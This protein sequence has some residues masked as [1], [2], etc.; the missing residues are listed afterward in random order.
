[1]S[2]RD[3]ARTIW[4]AALSGLS[5]MAP[6]VPL[7]LMAASIQHIVSSGGILDTI[8]YSAARAFENASPF[9]GALLVFFSALGIEFFI[10]SGSAKAFLVMPI[11]LP[12]GDLVGITRQM[13]VTAYC[14]GDGFTNLAYPTSA[15]L[16][17]CLG[18]GSV[19]YGRWLRW[20]LPLW[21][22]LLLI[23]LI[24]LALGT[25]IGLGP[26]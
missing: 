25:A 19:S 26:I 9:G 6:A 22:G 20:T 16:L 14:F 13:V 4:Q 11:L 12:L 15:V 7:I 8:L 3:D 10:S 1:M 24:F 23:T 2:A 17:I 5:G 18:L 21:L